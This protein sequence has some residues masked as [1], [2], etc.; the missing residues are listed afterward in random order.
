MMEDDY[1]FFLKP[2]DT[3]VNIYLYIK[4]Q[5]LIDFFR[6]IGG[7]KDRMQTEK[8]TFSPFAFII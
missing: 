7:G 2:L 3:T 4:K 1:L 6:I 8:Q 5:H